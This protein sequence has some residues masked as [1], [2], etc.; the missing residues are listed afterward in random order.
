MKGTIFEGSRTPLKQ[1]FYAI[2]TM[3]ATRSGVSAKQLERELGV[4]YKT[5]WRMFRQIRILMQSTAHDKISGEIEI[6]ETYVGGRNRKHL[7]GRSLDNKTPVLGIVQR[8]GI[9]SAQKVKNCKTSTIMPIIKEHVLTFSMI[10]TD[11]FTSYNELRRSHY[12]H[13]KVNHSTNQWV[14]DR[15]HTNTIEGFWSTLKR[16]ING[17]YH[18]VSRKYLQN[19]VDEYVF[20]YNHRLD[21]QPMFLTIL[22]KI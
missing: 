1:W 20:R 3:S 12:F 13:K 10:Y 14:D 7:G 17:V 6:D 5:A 11:E 15:V 2:F 18:S 16:G 9:L 4:T 22:E 21:K 19:Y 8:D